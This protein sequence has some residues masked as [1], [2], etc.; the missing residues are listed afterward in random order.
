MKP[1]EMSQEEV[2]E[3]LEHRDVLLNIQA[4]IATGPGQNFFKYLFKHFEVAELPPVGMDGSLLMDKLGSLRAGNAI[5]KLV[6]EAN[7]QLA[8]SILAQVERDKYEYINKQT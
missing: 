8:G 6:S 4:I 3:R 1:N 2:S 5:F 7:P